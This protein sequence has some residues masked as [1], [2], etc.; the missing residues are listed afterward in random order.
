MTPRSLAKRGGCGQK[1]DVR[2]HYKD[3]GF[4]LL[5]QNPKT[6]GFSTGETS[7][8]SSPVTLLGSLVFLFWI[9]SFQIWLLLS[10]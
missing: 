4:S 3:I 10:H 7:Q 5:K 9:S 6:P 2:R 1:N 8:L